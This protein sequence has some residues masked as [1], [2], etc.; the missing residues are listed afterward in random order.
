MQV[1]F[2]SESGKDG[3]TSDK[4]GHYRERLSGHSRIQRGLSLSDKDR[5]Y[6][7]NTEVWL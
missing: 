2:M 1:A 3:E 6:P 7:M 4:R 5:R